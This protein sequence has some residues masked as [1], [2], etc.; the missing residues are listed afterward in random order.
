MD[1]K[2]KHW[3]LFAIREHPGEWVHPN[4]LFSQKPRFFTEDIGDFISIFSKLN[5]EE[6]LRQDQPLGM[7]YKITPKG[8]K[9]LSRYL[10]R[11]KYREFLEFAK[12]IPSFELRYRLRTIEGF[13]GSFI[14]IMILSLIATSLPKDFPTWGSFILLIIFIIF[15]GLF[16]GL[17]G[18]I[19]FIFIYTLAGWISSG[20]QETIGKYK[21][22]LLP[23]ITL[24]FVIGGLWAF[25]KLSKYDWSDVLYLIITG[26]IVGLV[27]KIKEVYHYFKNKLN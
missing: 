18:Q 1:E 5:N 12:T 16:L 2:K 13:L 7:G 25:V 27:L 8:K 24:A 4:D 19:V 3:I 17:S 9:E 11:M 23:M 14:I 10:Q 22:Y 20:L 6:F 21:K 26:L 15:F